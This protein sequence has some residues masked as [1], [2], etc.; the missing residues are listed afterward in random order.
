MNA[1]SS[2][3]P[4]ELTLAIKE[5]N[6]YYQQKQ[7]DRLLEKVQQRLGEIIKSKCQ[8]PDF[9]NYMDVELFQKQSMQ[10]ISM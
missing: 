5:Y 6:Q 7:Y 1:R 4:G 9:S 8:I 10:Q 2:I 3:G